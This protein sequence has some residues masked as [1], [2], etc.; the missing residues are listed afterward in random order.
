MRRR[1]A[2]T[3]GIQASDLPRFLLSALI[4]MAILAPPMQSA[5]LRGMHLL[6][7]SS[8]HQPRKQQQPPISKTRAVLAASARSSVKSMRQARLQPAKLTPSQASF[9]PAGSRSASL[10]GLYRV[11]CPLRC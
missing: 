2:A 4:A 1:L 9:S 8:Q 5:A 6:Y 11:F 10:A 3:L 7:A